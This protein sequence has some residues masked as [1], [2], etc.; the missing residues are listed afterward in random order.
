MSVAELN[1]VALSVPTPVAARPAVR[2]RL[3]RLFEVMTFVAIVAWAVQGS[4]TF[5]EVYGK[6][7]HI[8]AVVIG[9]L[10]FAASVPVLLVLRYRIWTVC[11]CWTIVLAVFALRQTM[12]THRLAA[13]RHE[14]DSI[15]E[16]VD[17]Y[18]VDGGPYPTD[19]SQYRFHR[20]ELAQY[21]EYR[22]AYPVTSYEIRWHPVA[23]NGITHGYSPDFGH[24]YEDD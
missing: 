11:R 17:E 1:A 18:R 4:A 8:R 21:I 15:I 14:V 3:R 10:V 9:G 12:L 5:Y 23:F 20:P 7:A 19:L 6:G 22:D 2:F 13:L 24:Y 16:Y